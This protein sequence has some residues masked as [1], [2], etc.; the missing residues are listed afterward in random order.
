LR[1]L[2]RETRLGLGLYQLLT[3]RPVMRRFLARSW[4]SDGFDQRLLVHGR[5]CADL[6]GAQR[7]PLDFVSGSLFTRGIVER[8]R[9]LPVPVWVVHGNQGSFTDF[10]ACPLPTGGRAGVV[11]RTVIEG[12]AMPHFQSADAFDSAY[13]TFVGGMRP[14]AE[15]EQPTVVA[16]EWERA[17]IAELN[18]G[19]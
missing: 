5:V 3:T 2:L 16:R 15:L 14:Q 18:H 1:R 6:P 9:A 4:G 12:G 8:Y 10:D 13:E 17:L 7:A 11:G 19:R